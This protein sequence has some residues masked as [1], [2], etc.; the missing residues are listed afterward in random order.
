VS[1]PQKLGTIKL[2]VFSGA[3]MKSLLNFLRV[4]KWLSISGVGVLFLLKL[5]A[6]AAA[7]LIALFVGV[8]AISYL[9]PSQSEHEAVDARVR[10]RLIELCY[11]DSEKARRLAYA[12]SRR[13]R[14]EQ[15]AW[16]KAVEDLIRDRR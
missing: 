13:G 7:V 11:G 16:E 8:I 4:L 6:I 14:S 12:A 2:I 1:F 5:F 15:W 9:T 3:D 10:R